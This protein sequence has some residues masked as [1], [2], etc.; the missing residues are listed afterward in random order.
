MA[1]T[2]LV[3]NE[4]D[5]RIIQGLINREKTRVQDKPPR[6]GRLDWLEGTDHHPPETYVAYPQ[7]AGGI[8]A[9]SAGTGAGGSDEPGSATCD[10]YL[11]DA[12]GDLVEP[13]A[14]F[15]KTVY[16]L[17][18]DVLAQDW[19]TVTRTKYGKWIAV[20]SGSS[21]PLVLYEIAGVGAYDATSKEWKYNGLLV[22][23]NDGN[24]LWEVE[25]GT[26]YKVLW[27]PTA[28]REDLTD[29]APSD[30]AANT[31]VNFYVGQRV[32]GQSRGGRIEIVSPPLHEWRF[33]L[34]DNLEPDDASATAY[35]RWWTGAA[36]VTSTTIEIEVYDPS[37]GVSSG[38]IYYGRGRQLMGS[39]DGS[40]GIAKYWPDSDRWEI[41]Q[42]TPHT[43]KIKGLLTAALGEGDATKNIDNIVVM[44]PT[45]SVVCPDQLTVGGGNYVGATDA[46]YITCYNSSWFAMEGDDNNI[47]V[48][49]WNATD[50]KWYFTQ[51]ECKA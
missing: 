41:K 2:A 23:Y 14:S 29:D 49:E 5:K 8:P 20:V 45:G 28:H 17:T 32:Y 33:E 11:I 42:L 13:G 1:V 36:W 39:L 44:Q 18:T 26:D 25:G 40:I 15:S 4:N 19:M 31:Q 21:T 10:I 27:H 16:N 3:L 24:D 43:L 48:A 6:V 9:L 46:T 50:E 7:S 30:S 22:E 34:K 47:A 38:P 12:D 35:P 51:V 37:K